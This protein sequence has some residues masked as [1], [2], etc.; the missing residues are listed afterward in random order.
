MRITSAGRL[1]FSSKAPSEQRGIRTHNCTYS[2]GPRA[3]KAASGKGRLFPA[4]LAGASRSVSVFQSS[5]IQQ[6]AALK[7][8][9]G[10]VQPTFSKIQTWHGELGISCV[11]IDFVTTG[12]NSGPDTLWWA[13][14]SSFC[15]LLTPPAL[16]VHGL[17]APYH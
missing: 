11:V 2:S 13:R 14:V 15:L 12:S 10:T 16:A 1:P 9:V 17:L 4:C 5:L 6:D 3:L 7:R 8:R